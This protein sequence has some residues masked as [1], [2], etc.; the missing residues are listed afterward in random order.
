MTS[1]EQLP[2]ATLVVGFGNTLAGDDG[3]GPVVARQL[4]ALDL[5]PHARV[6]EARTDALELAGL[7][8]GELQVWMVDALIRGAAPGTIH[9]LDHDEVMS[10]AQHHA[11]V[12]QLSLPEC[13]RWLALAEPAMAGVRYRLYGV[14]PQWLGLSEGL[15]PAVAAAANRLVEI[16]LADLAHLPG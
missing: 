10:V 2:H 3:V 4:A 13:L 11:T 8:R 16:L 6:V 14:E 15:G 7:W 9:R 5:P 12:H 1:P